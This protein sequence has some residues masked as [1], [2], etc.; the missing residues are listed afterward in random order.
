MNFY[1]DSSA[2]LKPLLREDDWEAVRP[3]LRRARTLVASTLVYAEVMAALA[4]SHRART[5]TTSALE[6]S[7]RRVTEAWERVN[8][9]E[10]VSPIARAAGVIAERHSLRAADAV[11]L[12]TAL[13]VEDPK[14]VMV[15]W[16]K[17][18]HAA[19]LEAGLAVAPAKP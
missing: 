9:V 2:V 17:R 11:H 12:A 14:L 8:E 19:S 4:A 5:L 1:L 13:A 18:L 6:R 3:I 15:T 7:K 16:D 10:V